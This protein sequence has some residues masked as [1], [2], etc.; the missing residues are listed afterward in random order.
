MYY[1]VK[2]KVKT[3]DE[4]TG[5][6]KKHIELYLVKA[7]SVTDAEATVIKKEFSNVGFDYEILSASTSPIIKVVEDN[8]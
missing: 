5:K 7:F 2:V 8:D 4:E 1:L 6:I 3:Q